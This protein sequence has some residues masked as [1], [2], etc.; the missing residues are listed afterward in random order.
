M[1]SHFQFHN[2]PIFVF[3]DFEWYLYQQN[4]ESL[5]TS[6]ISTYMVYHYV[7]ILARLPN[8]LLP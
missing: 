7:P 6:K 4:F 1:G 2:G 3:Q 8:S 5:Y